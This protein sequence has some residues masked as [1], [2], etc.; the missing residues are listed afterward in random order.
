MIS[1]A[2]SNNLM[3]NSPK[4]RQILLKAVFNLIKAQSTY[5]HTQKFAV[6]NLV[7]TL[8]R[9][10]LNRY[11]QFFTYTLNRLFF[12]KYKQFFHK[13]KNY[14]IPNKFGYSPTQSILRLFYFLEYMRHKNK[15]IGFRSLRNFAQVKDLS[16]KLDI[17]SGF[18]KLNSNNNAIATGFERQQED[19]SD[20][21]CST[22]FA[23][24]HYLIGKKSSSLENGN[25]KISGTSFM[26]TSRTI[27][28]FI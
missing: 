28:S 8:H 20:G 18:I 1:Q 17:T 2:I 13:Y 5:R 26:A 21:K 7:Q 12:N 9:L 3:S 16:N 15:R 11:K 10:V 27:A 23:N 4:A 24:T 14:G 25:S 6:N 19:S 22:Y